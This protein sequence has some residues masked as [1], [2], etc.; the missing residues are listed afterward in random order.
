MA[1]ER[2]NFENGQVLDAEHLKCIEDCLCDASSVTDSFKFSK[3]CVG[4]AIRVLAVDDAG[5]PIKWETVEIPDISGKVDKTAIV[6]ATGLAE[7]K[8]MSQKAV[9][10]A[11]DGKQ[12]SGDYALKTELPAVPV[13]SVNGKTGDVNLS[14]SD[15]GALPDSSVSQAVG[16]SPLLVMSQDAVSKEITKLYGRKAD[17]TFV[18]PQM[19]GA[20]ADGVTDDTDA[21]QSAL[22]AGGVVY[23]P[24]GRYKVTR[25]LTAVKSCKIAM[26]KPYPCTYQGDYPLAEADNWMGCRIETYATDGYGLLIGDGVEVDG[27]YMRAMDDFQGVLLKFDGTLGKA[28]YPSQVRLAHI[29]LD[30]NSIQ[31]VPEAMFDFNPH[32]VY[33]CLL[34]DICIGSLRGRQFCRCGF[35]AN[36]A[37]TSDN[38]ANSVRIKNLCIDL[39]ADYS[40]YVEGGPKGCS[41]WVFEGLSVQTYPYK[42]GDQGYLDKTGHVDVVTLKNMQQP[43]FLGAHIW[44]LSA[45]TVT[46]KVIR[47]EN[48]TGIACFG[49]NTPF[50]A[51]EEE[52]TE[53]LQAAADSLNIDTLEMSVEGVEETGA[54]R[55]K[56]SDGTHEKSVDIPSVSISDEQLNTGIS[57]WFAENAAPTEVPGRNKFNVDDPDVT[58]GTLNADGTIYRGS[59]VVDYT[60]TGFMPAKTGDSVAAARHDTGKRLS[61]YHAAFYNKD[62]QILALK[63]WTD[64]SGAHTIDVEGV[65]FIRLEWSAGYFKFADRA[66]VKLM[67]TTDGSDPLTYEEYGVELVGGVG[68]FLVLQAPNGTQ[69]TLAVNDDG[70]IVAEP[71]NG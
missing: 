63:N 9:S 32:G 68:S 15:V 70:T 11:L 50:R 57:A 46:G 23:F 22:D 54:N 25:Q 64:T 47:A 7:D 31:T 16:D 41:N 2:Q 48:T 28:T 66:S 14:A 39:L 45:A 43:L 3:D 1:Y 21:V 8:I 20:A 71:V 58:Y 19:F 56:L 33:F 6:H 34:D 55:L 18:T 27:L 59:S 53:Q 69:Y 4:K 37:T 26:E 44:D 36:M 13:K 5:R 60:I 24:P 30:N 62:K 67:I 52:L 51:V 35:R 10:K 29:R 17:K 61:A 38:W 49:C 42:V 40:L 65:E 12:P